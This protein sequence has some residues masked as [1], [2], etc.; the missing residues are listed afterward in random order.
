[1]S[2][3]DRIKELRGEEKQASFGAHFGKNRDTI[4]RYE[5][6]ITQP[7]SDFLQAICR[8][9]QVSPTWL[10]LGDGEKNI[11]ESSAVGK[12]EMMLVTVKMPTT[13]IVHLDDNSGQLTTMDLIRRTISNYL[14]KRCPEDLEIIDILL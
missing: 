5:T 13:F 6:G 8:E 1:M 9:Y 12:K 10:L 2:L 4:R 14:G 11:K 7:D 3:G